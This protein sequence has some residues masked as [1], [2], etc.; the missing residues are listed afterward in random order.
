MTKQ[1]LFVPRGA[2]LSRSARAHSR[3]P[4][5][6]RPG[7]EGGARD[8]NRRERV[9][10]L[11]RAGL[12]L[13]LE[14]G[15]DA[16]TVDGV[17]LAAGMAKGSFY[18]YFD[19]LESLVAHVVKPVATQLRGAFATCEGALLAAKTR[20]ALVDAYE[21]LA[22]QLA[23]IILAATDVVRLYLQEARGAKRGARAPLV[24]L[25]TDV[26]R[27]ALGLTEAAQRHG[28]LRPASPFVSS[29]AVVGAVEELVFEGLTR[30]K[31][32]GPPAAAAAELV[33]LVLEGL[34]PR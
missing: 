10:S 17:V 4:P 25:A 19:D 12:A 11:E 2:G 33:G 20:E 18:R 23:V 24:L 8:K 26:R 13:F 29:H 34:R 16:V 28:L 7:P 14:Q 5:K 32:L 9:A 15:L 30:P 21:T 1:S 22:A 3:P 6:E 27:H 31:R